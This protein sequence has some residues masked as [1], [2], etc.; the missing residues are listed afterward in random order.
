MAVC[1]N[2]RES[3]FLFIFKSISHGVN[4]LTGSTFTPEVLIADG[5]DAI[6]NAFQNFFNKNKMVTCWSHMRRNVEKKLK[7]LRTDS[8]K[9]KEILDDIDTLQLCESETVFRNVLSLFLKKWSKTEKEFT[10]Y[11]ENE[12]LTV[13]DSWYEGYYGAFTPSTNNQLE[14]T[15][16]VIKDEHTFR[17]RHPL[18]R[19]LIVAS[20]IV[21]KWS[22]SRNRNQIDPVVFS[23]EP[24]IPLAKWTNAYHF[25]KSSKSVLQLQSKRKGFTDYY[26][27]AGDV[28][29]IT[30]NEIQRYKRKQWNSFTQ[31]KELQF[32]IWKVT[33][34]T[35]G[36][37]WEMNFAIAPIF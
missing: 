18:S 31:F 8:N 9:T 19:F 21:N 16:K 23:T 33:L 24:T 11:F 15:N 20:D 27:P 30:K 13:L 10:E 5:S 37:E 17:E 32:G 25:A 29:N 36:S 28:V 35:I 12:W 14:A 22:M 26:I 3:D 4:Q 6:R 1:S 2:E 34:P 7:S